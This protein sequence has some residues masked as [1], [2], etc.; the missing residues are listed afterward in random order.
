MFGN[1]RIVLALDGLSLQEATGFVR[2]FGDRVA[3][4]IHDLWDRHGPQTCMGHLILTDNIHVFVDLKL[5]DIPKTVELRT[6]AVAASG[7]RVLTVHASGGIEMMKSAVKAA[8]KDLKILAIT[9]LTSL[10]DDDASLIYG[11]SSKTAVLNS[12]YL[13]NDAGVHGLVC[14]PQEVGMLAK[15]P[16]LS[17]LPKVCPGV[18]S[19]G[20]DAN[21]QKR[22]DTPGQAIKSGASYLVVGREIIQASDPTKALE[23]IVSQLPL[24]NKA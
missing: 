23:N 2:L 5:H 13:A 7:A 1:T 9:V 12:A 6:K 22:V 21:D 20:I 24:S 18:R 11:S 3:Y 19:E 14:S 17:G 4:K 16:E 15:M 8:G 10:T